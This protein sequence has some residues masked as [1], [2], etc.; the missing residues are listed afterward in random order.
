MDAYHS[1]LCLGY[2]VAT[3]QS[4]EVRHLTQITIGGAHKCS[5]RQW[6]QEEHHHLHESN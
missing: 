2:E 3:L 4:P 5:V 1:G 6:V